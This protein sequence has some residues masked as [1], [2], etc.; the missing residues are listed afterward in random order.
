M[1]QPSPRALRLIDLFIGDPDGGPNGGRDQAFWD[2][3]RALPARD[4]E[5]FDNATQAALRAF[6]AYVEADEPPDG[7]SEALRG[8]RRRSPWRR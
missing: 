3:Y 1:T 6:M 8:R 2:A 7:I 5:P 4:R